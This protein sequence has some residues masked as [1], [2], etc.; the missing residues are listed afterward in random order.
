MKLVLFFLVVGLAG[1]EVEG[2]TS[3]TFDALPSAPDAKPVSVDTLPT[4]VDTKP[5]A[6]DT[7]PTAVDTKPLPV[8]TL[9]PAGDTK[10]VSVDTLPPILDTLPAYEPVKSRKAAGDLSLSCPIPLG[11]KPSTPDHTISG[12]YH[13][14]GDPQTW[15]EK[16]KTLFPQ[17]PMYYFFDNDIRKKL[18][19]IDCS[20]LN[21]YQGVNLCFNAK[22]QNVYD[23]SPGLGSVT[24]E[25]AL[26]SIQDNKVDWYALCSNGSFVGWW[27]TKS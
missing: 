10:P 7:L 3:L 12:Y 17:Y 22:I 4:T 20:K 8:D 14:A 23:P 11:F 24:A 18:E 27:C 21:T 1:C 2:V 13:V 9:P 5:L 6:V 19:T 16:T 25:I 15:C 26:M